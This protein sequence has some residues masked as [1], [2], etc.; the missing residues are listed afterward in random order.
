M[1]PAFA[2]TCAWAVQASVDWGDHLGLLEDPWEDSWEDRSLD[3]SKSMLSD[4]TDLLLDD[5]WAD[6]P[7]LAGVD[8]WLGWCG[9]PC[10]AGL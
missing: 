3:Q 9:L 2:E 5:C 7:Y 6:C 10:C 8:G 1:D 4:I